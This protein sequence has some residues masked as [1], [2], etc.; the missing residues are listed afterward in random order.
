MAGTK[1]KRS[2]GRKQSGKRFAL[3]FGWS[4]LIS[5]VLLVGIALVWAFIFGVIIGRGYYPETLIPALTRVVPQ[6]EQAASART[7]PPSG[8][9]LH[10]DELG[11]FDS[12]TQGGEEPDSGRRARREAAGPKN[13]PAQ[14]Q[15]EQEV[16]TG[17]RYEY[18]YQIAALKSEEQAKKVARELKAKGMDVALRMVD[19][20]GVTW[21]RVQVLFTGGPSETERFKRRLE[22]F[23]LGAPFLRDKAKLE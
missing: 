21:Y 8:E 2:S 12:L 22:G 5:T 16:R 7:A 6:K 17:G 14:Q 3:T 10:A 15:A 23:G 1:K 19:K 18:R 20:D 11:F 13:Q 4:G 9:P